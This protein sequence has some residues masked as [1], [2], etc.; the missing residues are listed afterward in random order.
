MQNRFP[1]TA[2]NSPSTRYTGYMLGDWTMPGLGWEPAMLRRCFQ[3]S[4]IWSRIYSSPILR[5]GA[6]GTRA[7]CE[8]PRRYLKLPDVG[9]AIRVYILWCPSRL[10]AGLN[11]HLTTLLSCAACAV[12]DGQV[13]Q[14]AGKN[15]P[16]TSHCKEVRGWDKT[17]HPPQTY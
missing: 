6:H 4:S 10:K 8:L 9:P 7:M 16:W 2:E 5:V 11:G 13:D 1:P 17:T 12:L 15:M 14:G 3:N